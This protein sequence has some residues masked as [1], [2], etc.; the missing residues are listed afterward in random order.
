MFTTAFAKLPQSI[1]Q[2]VQIIVH[3]ASPQ[4][5]ILFG[6]RATKK[7]RENSDFDIAA[8]HKTCSE[9]EWNSLLLQIQED[10]LSLYSVDIVEYEKLTQ[11]YR[12]A[13][14]KEGIELWI[15]S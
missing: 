1:Q 14:D 11:I 10:P 12:T 4:A 13:I 7:H 6:S 8:K 3:K 2:I 15:H 9:A 5:V